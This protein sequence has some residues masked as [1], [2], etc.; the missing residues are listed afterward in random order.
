LQYFDFGV[1]NDTW[2]HLSLRGLI[3]A[4]VITCFLASFVSEVRPA[5]LALFCVS[6]ALDPVK[7]CFPSMYSILR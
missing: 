3:D 4:H 5:L 7:R 6:C 2:Q 1:S